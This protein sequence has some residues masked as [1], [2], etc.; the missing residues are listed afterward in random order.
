M[1]RHA[2]VEP[3]VGVEPSRRESYLLEPT[4]AGNR[5]V[6]HH[7]QKG[8]ISRSPVSG[9]WRRAPS[10]EYGGLLL[11]PSWCEYMRALV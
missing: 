11:T 5:W 1:N 9:H 8:L 4:S 10:G 2:D 7:V 3:S 6:T